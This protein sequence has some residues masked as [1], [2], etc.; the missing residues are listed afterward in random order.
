LDSTGLLN[1]QRISSLKKLII[2]LHKAS[3]LTS[4]GSAEKILA[5]WMEFLSRKISHI[6]R[7]QEAAPGKLRKR[8]TICYNSK[9]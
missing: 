9:K 7:Y 4:E 2:C 6:W 8:K 5:F 3:R 1:S